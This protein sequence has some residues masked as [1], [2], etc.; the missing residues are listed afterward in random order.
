VGADFLRRGGDSEHRE[1]AY[2]RNLVEL[3]PEFDDRALRRRP[4][5]DHRAPEITILGDRWNYIAFP[6][7]GF[8]FATPYEQLTVI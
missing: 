1:L 5:I 2:E 8:I 7:I 6:E 4:S 3:A